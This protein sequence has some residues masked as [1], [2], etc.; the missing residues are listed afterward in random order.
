M[1][2][3]QLATAALVFACSGPLIAA[4]PQNQSARER[5]EADQAMEYFV[6][7]VLKSRSRRASALA[8]SRMIPD[9]LSFNKAGAAIAVYDCLPIAA[10]KLSFKSEYFRLTLFSG[11]YFSDFNKSG[12]PDFS[13]T[14]ALKFAS[15]F[16]GPEGE[17]PQKVLVLRQF[18]DCVARRGTSETHTLLL[19]KIRSKEE[20]AAWG[21]VRPVLNQCIE[22]KT[23]IAFT[24]SVLRGVLAEAM[25]K[26]RKA[27][28]TAPERTN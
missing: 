8:F 9:T 7:C 25:F 18:G 6:G 13:N 28:S 17:I 20:N 26:L 4:A 22:T 15:E 27:Q 16:D 23:D 5:V 11:L 1:R 12:A 21:P 3:L 19:T 2:R 14:P 24:R 10:E